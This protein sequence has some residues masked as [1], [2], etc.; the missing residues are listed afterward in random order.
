MRV[1][2]YERADMNCE[3]C[4]NIGDLTGVGSASGR[5]SYRCAGCGATWRDKGP[6]KNPAAVALGALGGKARAE[7]LSA[8]ARSAQAAVAG[9]ARWAREKTDPAPAGAHG[10]FGGKPFV[11]R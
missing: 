9:S 10:M 6:E 5:K 4:G 3:K 2:S 8:E 7:S 11:S 1:V